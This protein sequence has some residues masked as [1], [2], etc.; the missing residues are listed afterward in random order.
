MLLPSDAAPDSTDILCSVETYRRSI[1]YLPPSSTTADTS[2]EPAVKRLV[3]YSIASVFTP[4]QNRKKGYA[5]R[6]ME[7]LHDQLGLPA[8][9]SASAALAEL[10]EEEVELKGADGGRDGLLSWLYSDVGDFYSRCHRGGKPEGESWQI[11]G[12]TTTTWTIPL[13]ASSS[14]VSPP[15]GFTCSLVKPTDFDR[16]AKLDASSL[17]RS[18]ASSSSP[19]GAFAAEPTDGALHWATQRGA[20]SFTARGQE[21]PTVWGVELRLS[22][23]SSSNVGEPT[24]FI[25]FTCDFQKQKAKLLRLLLSS[26]SHAPFLLSE[27]SRLL[28]QYHQTKLVGWKVPEE[29]LE[30]LRQF[31]KGWAGE[32]GERSDSLS[33]VA[34]YGQ[35]GEGEVEW[36]VN[37]GYAWC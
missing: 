27:A 16:L 6:M 10:K 30:E 26:P 15:K 8:S 22:S 11:Q 17:R 1:L 18:F 25:L 4:P 7:L 31:G 14:P 5:K 36:R 37:E 20:H 33:A 2:A 19:R 3:G 21:A 28:Q 35:E 23:P 9:N 24:S 34:W 13:P 32:T 12:L 29:A